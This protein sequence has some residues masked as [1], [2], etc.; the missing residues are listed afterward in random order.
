MRIHEG[1]L[2]QSFWTTNSTVSGLPEI[3]AVGF[4]L[5]EDAPAFSLSAVI[6]VHRLSRSSAGKPRAIRGVCLYMP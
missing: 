5:L 3:S 4:Q 1:K 2:V 6:N